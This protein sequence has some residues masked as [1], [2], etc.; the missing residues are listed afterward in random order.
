ML[1][2]QKEKSRNLPI[3]EYYSILHLEYYSYLVRSRIYINEYAAKY[4]G[5]CEQKKTH[6]KEIA[7]K[8]QFPSIFDN[9]MLIDVYQNKFLND[10]GLPNFQY[11]DEKSKNIMGYWDKFYY[12][13]KST[14]IKIISNN[15]T[16]ITTVL[17]N[18][19]ND[20]RIVANVNNKETIF[21]YNWVSR[22]LTDNFLEIR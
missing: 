13:Q 21:D 14:P 15:K 16:V 20:C 12:F 22:I 4:R 19:P 7:D 10:F 3:S 17:K 11:K 2:Q 6:I 8:K 18:F 1:E 5:Y 9:S